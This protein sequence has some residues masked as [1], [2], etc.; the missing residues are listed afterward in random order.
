MSNPLTQIV[1]QQEILRAAGDRRRHL[2]LAGRQLTEVPAAISHVAH[3]E[4]LDLSGNQLTAVPRELGKFKNLQKL[5]L[6]SNQLTSLP[7]ELADLPRTLLLNL[8][9]N[10]LTEPYASLADQGVSFLF[11]YLDSLRSG[12]PQY[13]AK[14]LMVG[15]GNVGKSSLLAALRDQPFVENRATTH[16]IE[17]GIL[18][19]KHPGLTSTIRLN[20]WDFGGQEVYR[21]THQFF[22]SRQ[23]LYLLVWRPREGQA[24]NAIEEWCR[25]I[26]LRVGEDARILIVA[27][28]CDERNP[29]L[30]YPELRRQFGEIL[31][32]HHG[33]DNRTGKGIAELREMLGQQAA[34]LPQMGLVINEHWMAARDDILSREEPQISYDEFRTVCERFGLSRADTETLASLLDI[35]GHVIYYGEDEGLRDIVVLQPEWLT[36][37]IGYVLEDRPTRQAGGV[38]EHRRLE[39]LWYRPQLGISYRSEYYPYF[40][41][42]M[43]KFDVSYRIPDLDASLIGQ[44]VPFERPQSPWEFIGKP[45]AHVRS[46][47]VVCSLGEEAPGL[48]AWLT[49]RNHR[50]SVNLH[51]RRGV[52]LNHKDYDSEALFELISDRALSLT[53]RAPS[54]DYFFSLLYDSLETLIKDRWKGLHYEFLVPCPQTLDDGAQCIGQFKHRILRRF[55]EQGEETILCHE[56]IR[57]QSIAR[58]LT[59]FEPPTAPLESVLEEMRQQRHEVV[60]ELRRITAYTAESA[61]QVR[62][63]LKAVS[64]EIS[65]CP[66]LFT[67][68]P[69]RA[70]GI[71]RAKVWED[72]F[73]L[74]LWCEHPG[75]EHPWDDAIYE[76]SRPKEWLRTVGPY[77]VLVSKT[78]RLVVPIAGATSEM[79][80]PKHQLERIEHEIELMKA[81][82]AQLPD[83]QDEDQALTN[84]EGGLSRVEGAELRAFRSLLFSEDSSRRFGKLRRVRAMSGEFLWVCPNHQDYYDPGLP[85]LPEQSQRRGHASDVEAS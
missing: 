11:T 76:F 71:S 19:I 23:A 18:R 10:P 7:P 39:E 22:F 13:E 20:T 15:E 67:L 6:S 46:L 32:G 50:F 9:G 75:N 28:H 62:A 41:R 45:M 47:S 83:R 16:G 34:R 26:R 84:R 36:K 5:N 63:V 74:T 58:L 48:I 52:F 17:L 29:E 72:H 57:P 51:W 35:L 80:L 2:N 1:A 12:I 24:E 33:V 78:L 66:R 85:T 64:T 73:R 68:A 38:L 54:P 70:G 53:V 65:D 21:I 14:V 69:R 81:V 60:E 56:C 82:V 4:S 30:D 25:L 44:L 77:V 43:E 42:L 3:I 8:A 79:V 27:T 61:R 37:A 40:L 49:V 59:G 31:V 55:R